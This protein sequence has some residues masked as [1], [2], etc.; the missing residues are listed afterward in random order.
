MGRMSFVLPPES[1]RK[2]LG[3]EAARDVVESM[4]AI[5]ATMHEHAV[6]LMGERL[7]RRLV[8][9]KG[10]LRGEMAALKSELKGDMAALKSEFKSDLAALKSELTQQIAEARADLIKWMFVFWLGQAA[11]VLGIVQMIR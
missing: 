8:E 11:T 3:D 1:L 4:H 6:E 2:Q 9:A 10:D 5:A 7:E